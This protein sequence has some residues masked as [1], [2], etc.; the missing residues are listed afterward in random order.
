MVEVTVLGVIMI[1]IVIM[2][3]SCM[4][5]VDEQLSSEILISP[6]SEFP[7]VIIG[8]GYRSN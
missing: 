1:M 8:H 5:C 7:V 3:V 6:L 2:V 4:G